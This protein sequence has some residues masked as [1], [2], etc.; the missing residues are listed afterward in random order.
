MEKTKSR[1]SSVPNI[2][3]WIDSDPDLKLNVTVDSIYEPMK[4]LSE[5][6]TGVFKPFR[7]CC[8]HCGNAYLVHFFVTCSCKASFCC[9]CVAQINNCTN[10]QQFLGATCLFTK[11]Q[12]FNRTISMHECMFQRKEEN[13]KYSQSLKTL[14]YTD[15]VKLYKEISSLL[16][17]FTDNRLNEENSNFIFY[18]INNQLNLVEEDLLIHYD[19]L[20]EDYLHK[21]L[22][23]VK[24]NVNY[25]SNVTK[26]THY[27][28]VKD[29]GE[30]INLF[31][32]QGQNSSER[33]K[34]IVNK[35]RKYDRK[36]LYIKFLFTIVIVTTLLLIIKL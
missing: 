36:I 25:I 16:D 12:M 7:D 27:K 8:K 20:F 35:T 10:C 32:Q 13:S 15:S 11:T 23:K 21:T 33:K 14:L 19:K 29:F 17:I 1:N 9:S 3:Y 4:Q 30:N 34:K 31:L 22:H 26:I 18:K 6:S 24:M 2:D 5:I 28:N